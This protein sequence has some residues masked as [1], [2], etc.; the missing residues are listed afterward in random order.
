MIQFGL[1]AF[2]FS[3]VLWTCDAVKASTDDSIV[4]D[5]FGPF[6]EGVKASIDDGIVQDKLTPFVKGVQDTFTSVQDKFTPFVNTFV[7]YFSLDK[8]EMPPII[9][10]DSQ[11]DTM[12]EDERADGPDAQEDE[13]FWKLKVV[14]NLPDVRGLSLTLEEK[15]RSELVKMFAKDLKDS[16]MRD[17][18]SAICKEEADSSGVRRMHVEAVVDATTKKL[19]FKKVPVT[20]KR[21]VASER[22]SFSAEGLLRQMT[23]PMEDFVLRSLQRSL[24]REMNI[25]CAEKRQ[26]IVD[27]FVDGQNSLNTSH[28]WSKR[29]FQLGGGAYAA[30]FK[31]IPAAN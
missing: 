18:T 10:T 19:T 14:C 12:N 21:S 26:D 20:Q 25:V 22:S 29:G 3:R 17:L 31:V 11:E 2:S 1:L 4:Q 16:D 6:V 30:V 8:G 7:R 13:Y 23:P 5:K 27:Q 9:D 24:T 28:V 15:E